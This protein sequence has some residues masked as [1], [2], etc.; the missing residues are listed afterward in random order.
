V[1]QRAREL[2]LRVNMR[3]EAEYISE[4]SVYLTALAMNYLLRGNFVQR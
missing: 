4:L 3:R 2:E 1:Q